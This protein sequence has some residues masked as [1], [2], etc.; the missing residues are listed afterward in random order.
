MQNN[1]NGPSFPGIQDQKELTIQ[2]FLKI[3]RALSK[4]GVSLL[5]DLAFFINKTNPLF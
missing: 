4:S 1:R 2:T 3:Q 5:V